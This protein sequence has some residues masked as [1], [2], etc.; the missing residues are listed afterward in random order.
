MNKAQL[1]QVW[2][3]FAS[4]SSLQTVGTLAEISK[5]AKKRFSEENL[6]NPD[7][8]VFVAM[9][10]NGKVM[11]LVLSAELSRQ[12]REKEL[13]L[14]DLGGYPIVDRGELGLMLVREQGDSIETTAE[15]KS[16]ASPKGKVKT[17]AKW[18]ELSLDDLVALGE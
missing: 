15:F 10:K 16:N 6:R 11:R 7:K 2:D 8:L 5:G 12:V 9:E 13:G 4:E 18:E 1:N 17:I 14:E 3:K